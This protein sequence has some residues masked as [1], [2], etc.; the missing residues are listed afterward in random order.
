MDRKRFS[1]NLRH[2]RLR[3]GYT[4]EQLAEKM[5]VSTQSVSRWECS[6]TLP[7][8]LQ[9]PKLARI[10]GTTVEDLF[11]EEVTYY[12][13]YAQRLLAVYEATGRTE[14]FVVAEQ[15]FLRLLAG[16]YSADDLRAFGVLYHYMMRYCADHAIQHLDAAMMSSKQDKQL[17]N[18]I[19]QQRIALLCDL[20]HGAEVVEEYSAKLN[21]D[22]SNDQNWYS[23]IVANHLAGENQTAL[24]LAQKAITLFPDNSTLHSYAGDICEALGLYEEAFTYW[25][26]AKEIDPAF[27]DVSYSMGAC[28]EELS[29]YSQAYQ[30]WDTLHK[31]LIR[32]G[33]VQECEFVKRHMKFCEEKICGR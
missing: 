11:R 14:D 6:N 26:R 18:R 7:D 29:K 22:Q 19:V 17:A 5:G 9:L 32:H 20:G 3:K 33:M 16:E 25:R 23:C 2:L 31:E 28:C 10:Y 24:D 13:N 30:V 4:Q 12:P 1:D 27:F 21:T 8:V 15:E